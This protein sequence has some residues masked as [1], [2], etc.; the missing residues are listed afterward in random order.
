MGGEEVAASQDAMVG[1]GGLRRD[2]LGVGLVGFDAICLNLGRH[3][4]Q[5]FA[6]TRDRRS[7]SSL[8]LL[9]LCRLITG[10]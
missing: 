4:G 6:S 8:P 5:S 3:G 10:R 9:L 7:S 1:G 2:A